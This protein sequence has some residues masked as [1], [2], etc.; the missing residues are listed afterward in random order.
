MQAASGRRLLPLL[1]LLGAGSLTVLAQP[2][3][4]VPAGRLEDVQ[5]GMAPRQLRTLLGAPTTTARQ[6]FYQGML[7]QWTYERPEQCRIDVL[8]R[9]GKEAQVFAIH[10]PARPR[11]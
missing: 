7:E 1:L 10:R 4:P 2:A 9:L 8:Y 5:L 3:P 6:I 11:P